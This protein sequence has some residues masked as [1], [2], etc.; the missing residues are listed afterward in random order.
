[1]KIIL[2]AVGAALLLGTSAASAQPAP[3]GHAQHQ[4]AAKHKP[5]TKSGCCCEKGMAEMKGMMA[6]MIRMHQ[7]MMQPGMKMP[8]DGK[9]TPRPDEHKH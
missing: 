4:H 9:T 3:A 1:M 5:T 7:G 2:G 6:E 8:T